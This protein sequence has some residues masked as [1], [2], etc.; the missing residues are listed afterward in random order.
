MKVSYYEL[1][2][3]IQEGN[4]PKK[5]EVKLCNYSRIYVAEY[6]A[7]EFSH[8]VL[9]DEHYED[10][11]YKYYLVESMLESTM[12]DKCIEIIEEDKEYEDIKELTQECFDHWTQAKKINSLIKNQ[13][14]L[15]DEVN[16][17][18]N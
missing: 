1:L 15:I 10:E 13:K 5:I 18:K 4:A 14:K 16:K 2:G 12:F 8:Y 7:E 17:L 11:N 9:K 3:M 6:D